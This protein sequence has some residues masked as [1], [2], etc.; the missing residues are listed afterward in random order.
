MEALREGFEP[1]RGASPT[2]SQG[3]R[4]SPGLATSAQSE[5]KKGYKKLKLKIKGRGGYDFSIISMFT[6]SGT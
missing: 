2:G 1:S 3:L 5:Y 6:P 4:L